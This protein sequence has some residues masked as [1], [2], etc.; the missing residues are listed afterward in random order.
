MEGIAP[1]AIVGE[2]VAPAIEGDAVG[3]W[4]IACVESDGIGAGIEAIHARGGGVEGWSPGMFEGVLEEDAA[5][6]VDGAIGAVDEVIGGVMGIGGVDSLEEDDA[7]IGDVIAVGVFEEEDIG[8]GGDDDA[9]VPE[10][11]AEGVLDFREFGGFVGDAVL[12]GIGKDEEAIVHGFEGFPFG[13]S[14]PASGPEA[15]FGIDLELD[16]VRQVGEAG[17]I[18]EEIE[19]EAVGNFYFGDGVLAGEVVGVSFF[20]GIGAFAFSAD[21]GDNLDGWRDIGIGEGE[22]L[23]GG[24]RPDFGV[25][26]GGHDIEHF[27]FVLEDL[28]VGLAVDEFEAR[29]TAPDVIAVGGAVAVM[30]V[31]VFIDDGLAEGFEGWGGGDGLAGEGGGDDFADLA[32][33]FGEGVD[34]VEGEGRFGLGVAG[35]GGGEEVD[36][37]DGFFFGDLFDGGGVE[38]E[39]DVIAGAVGEVGAFAIFVGDGGEEDET[40]SGF[41]VEVDGAIFID[42]RG[43]IGFELGETGFPGEGFIVAEE[44]EDD[45]GFAEGEGSFG[46]EEALMAGAIG[47]GVAVDGEVSEG[48]MEL[49]EFALDGGF[50]PAI[51]L[52]AVG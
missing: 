11:E 20:L 49:G 6:P 36:E 46:G 14:V 31:H 42:H 3:V 41:A 9:P 25:A 23:V 47:D 18:G 22:G 8:L 27:E 33:A 28:G 17:F 10:F 19:F 29:A 30:P 5:L 45:I 37:G 48:E 35:L 24:G 26:V 32:I 40:R 16:G 34:A 7:D 38:G 1:G 4:A 2:V 12:I 13:V 21:I 50:D 15:A 44:S 39:V 43:E 51:V 52:H